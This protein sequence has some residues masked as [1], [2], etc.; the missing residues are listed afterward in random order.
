MTGDGEYRLAM[1][2]DASALFLD[3]MELPADERASL[4]LKLLG[5]V[6][7]PAPD[8]SPERYEAWC[9]EVDGRFS[10]L[11][12]GDDPGEDWADVHHE[13]IVEFGQG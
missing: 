13:L 9:R 5:T 8:D 4:A 6:D 2:R 11:R 10:S 7:D 1:A 3:A 12:N